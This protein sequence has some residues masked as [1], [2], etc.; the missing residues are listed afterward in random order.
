MLTGTQVREFLDR[1]AMIGRS[2]LPI[3]DE[4]EKQWEVMKDLDRALAS[5]VG[6][7][8]ADVDSFFEYLFNVEDVDAYDNPD[9]M[10]EAFRA[11]VNMRRKVLALYRGEGEG[12]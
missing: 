6:G 12:Q 11:F 7:T 4:N 1:H 5:A 10:V 8:K 3:A 2:G 9:V